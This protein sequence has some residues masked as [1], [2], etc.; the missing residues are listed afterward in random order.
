[1]A[2][3]LHDLRYALRQLRKS[4]GFTLTAL[5]TLALGI[6]ATTAIFSLIQ[7]VLLHPAGIGDPARVM[8]LRV[9]YS[10]LNLASIGVSVPDFADALSL[11]KQVEYAALEQSGSFNSMVDGR[12]QHLSAANVTWQWFNVLGARPILGR[13]FTAD[14]DQPNANREVILNY[15]T[16]QRAF[17][18]QKDAIGKTILLDQQAYRVI[19]VMR[20]DFD[21]PRGRD[22]WVPLGLNPAAYSPDQRFDELYEG[23]AR[24]Q[25]GVNVAQLNA[26]LQSKMQELFRIYKNH[27]SQDS[28]WGMFAVPYT[29]LIAGQLRRPLYVLLGVVLAVLLI[30]CANV[31][32]LFLAR[33]AARSQEM[34]IRTAFGAPA[35]RLV[36]QL[37][38]ETLVLA[39]TA[40]L[41]GVLAGPPFGRLLLWMVPR[42]LAAGFDVRTE[43]AVLAFA[44]AAG[45]LTATLAGLAP[46][47]R[48]VHGQK[49]LRLHESVRNSTV[50]AERQRLRSALVIT[51]VALSLLL[52]T[53]TGLFLA[54]L[55]H[56]QHVNP[57]FESKGIL[58]GAVNL[59]GAQYQNDEQ[60]RSNF[61]VGVTQQLAQQP[62][63]RASAAVYPLPFS[64]DAP[65]GSFSVE[66]RPNRANDPG[67][68]SYR[69]W[70]TPGYLQVMR[71]Q[72]RAGRWFT[73][74]DREN[75]SPVVV[76]DENLARDYWPGQD[77]IGKY[78]RF[79]RATAWHQIVGVV[80]HVRLS[81]LAEDTGK[82]IVYEAYAQNPVPMANFIARTNGDPYAL[83]TALQRSVA[84]VDPSQ[85]IFDIDTLGSMVQESL[86]GRR[87][88]VWLLTGF[89]VLALV[90]AVVGIYGLISYAAA[91]RTTE[92]GIRMALGAERGQIVG[93][94]LRGAAK[95]MGTGLAIG[96]VLSLLAR[97]LLMRLFADMSATTLL[98]FALP[99]TVLAIVGL[100]AALVPARRAA[101]VDPMQALR[102]E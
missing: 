54:S 76:I 70:V 39:G 27:Y 50:S 92:I 28:G 78:L 20:S 101:S 53:G 24:L 91:Q 75:T 16:W 69:A 45:L 94:V 73:S 57:G 5:L 21:W 61:I 6:G 34:V 10:H 48:I 62:G 29:E 63:V 4:P 25:P 8:A 49:N 47:L 44:A 35:W 87:L 19:G 32:G 88:I 86:A 68:H 9:R 52:L 41:V 58:T 60:R 67:P 2:T 89:A 99:I 71:I 98:A 102:S 51:E 66:G 33:G 82:G 65:S 26:G 72:L 59:S 43:P 40:T 36:R 85:T 97:F 100:L 46:V 64:G 12:T 55:R 15:G 3:L 77:P 38:V 84:A 37:L 17:G 13:T 22:V 81:S 96:V 30:A 42:D 83:Q 31:A 74:E 95:L 79:G 18:G 11:K 1:M 23:I 56:L 14:E 7:A 80:S 93:M 90:L